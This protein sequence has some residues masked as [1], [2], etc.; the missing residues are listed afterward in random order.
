MK[1]A[2][3]HAERCLMTRLFL[4]QWSQF[5]RLLFA[6]WGTAITVMAV[7]QVAHLSVSWKLSIANLVCIN[8]T[9]EG[10]GFPP[11]QLFNLEYSIT[12]QV[13]YWRT[14]S[15]QFRNKKYLLQ[16][17]KMEDFQCFGRLHNLFKIYINYPIRA[18]FSIIRFINYIQPCCHCFSESPGI[19]KFAS[20]FSIFFI[21]SLSRR[22]SF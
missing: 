2:E 8:V 13:H 6:E 10:L 9:H 7:S 4:L 3:S 22:S 14:K 5:D 16:N 21:E 1:G 11:A 19:H 17:S 20:R 15:E 12:H 18:R